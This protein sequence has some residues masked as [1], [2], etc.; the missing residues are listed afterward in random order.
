MPLAFETLNRGTIAFGFFNIDVDMILLNH[1]FL[2]ADTFCKLVSNFVQTQIADD[3]H[4]QFDAY[5]IEEAD[6]IGD[7]MGAIHGVNYQGFIGDVYRR[8]PFPIKPEEFKQRPD[9]HK[10]QPIVEAMIQA[11]ATKKVLPFLFESRSSRITI[12][13]Y[14]FSRE[15]FGQL[16]GY[17]W[18]GG[19]PGW[20][21]NEKPSYVT[22]MMKDVLQSN[23]FFSKTGDTSR[24]H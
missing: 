12:G 2:F 11:Y 20:M 9:G 4:T 10:N 19:A 6:A 16:I 13:D 17:I 22:A 8:F 23:L 5:V 14:Q 3:Y 15:G 7:L 18:N 24:F 21:N 1:Y